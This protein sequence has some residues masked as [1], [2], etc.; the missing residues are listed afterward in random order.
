MRFYLQ[1]KFRGNLRGSSIFCV[2]LAWNDPYE[3]IRDRKLCVFTEIP[4]HSKI[5]TSMVTNSYSIVSNLEQNVRCSHG[6]FTANI[7]SL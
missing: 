2:D 7:C 3:L 4:G 6:N 1:T 5:A